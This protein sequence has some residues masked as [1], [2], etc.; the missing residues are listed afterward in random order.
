M[1]ISPIILS[2]SSMDKSASFSSA[3]VVPTTK[4]HNSLTD[5]EFNIIADTI[6]S[7][8]LKNQLNVRLRSL[9]QNLNNCMAKKLYGES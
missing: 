6:R 1:K 4:R 8:N 5:M 2:S 3:N 9:K 7:Q